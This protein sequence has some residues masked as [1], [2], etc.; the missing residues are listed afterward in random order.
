MTN[1]QLPSHRGTRPN[2]KGR[3]KTSKY[4]G[5]PS[6]A[7]VESTKR[8]FLGTVGSLN[9]PAKWPDCNRYVEA[10]VSKL[11]DRHPTPV[12]ARGRTTLRWSLVCRD[13][14]SIKDRASD[15]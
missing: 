14:K 1:N 2:K 6:H 5:K 13:Y 10:V 11:C 12:Q 15:V 8:C 4:A 3:F 7:G 9:G